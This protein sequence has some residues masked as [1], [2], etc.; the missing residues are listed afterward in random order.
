M[1]SKRR[2]MM[3]SH[4][5]MKS[6]KWGMML[7]KAYSNIEQHKKNTGSQVADEMRPSLMFSIG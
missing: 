3:R 7:L 1:S 5:H 2:Y 6:Q 4:A